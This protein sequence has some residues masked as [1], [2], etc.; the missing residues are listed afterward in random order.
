MRA[1]RPQDTGEDLVTP[2]RKEPS[3]FAGVL[4]RAK[5]NEWSFSSSPSAG[6]VF[7]AGAREARRCSALRRLEGASVILTRFVRTA[8]AA[9]AALLPLLLRCSVMGIAALLLGGAFSPRPFVS[10]QPR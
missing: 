10:A 5:L 6:A 1:A 4:H 3:R 7:A 9:A 8:A 2:R